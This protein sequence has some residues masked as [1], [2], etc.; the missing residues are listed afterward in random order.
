M[1]GTLSFGYIYFIYMAMTFTI[2]AYI[3]CQ[4]RILDFEFAR[5]DPGGSA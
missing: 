3:G 1:V 4:I 2:V 5:N